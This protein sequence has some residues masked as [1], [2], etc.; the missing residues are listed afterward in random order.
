[1]PFIGLGIVRPTSLFGTDK[2][3][4]NIFDYTSHKYSNE[5]RIRCLSENHL[6]ISN[7]YTGMYRGI[8]HALFKKK[9]TQTSVVFI[10]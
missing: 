8:Y 7:L 9:K 3:K 1:M 6:K 4:K 2:Q 5:S 10:R